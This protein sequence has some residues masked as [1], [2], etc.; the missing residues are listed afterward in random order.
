M[1]PFA[2]MHQDNVTIVKPDGRRLGPYKTNV[3][4]KGATIF[5]VVL[6]VDVDDLLER[7]LPGNKVELYTITDA[8]YSQGSIG[9][10]PHWSLKLR[11]GPV[12]N[13]DPVK[14]TTIN[15]NNSTG[16]QVGDHNTLHIEQGV[17]ELIK[18]IEQSG[19]PE[20]E[21]KEAK[22]GVA[23]MLKHPLVTSILG[24]AVGGLVK[25]LG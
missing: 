1:N 18:R 13:T 11:K 24:S 16:F 17:S 22:K 14:Q 2:S 15:I 9:I 25:L 8:H 5:E 12:K 10:G 7:V 4:S 6:D 19:R 3:G 21:I 23:E 20:A